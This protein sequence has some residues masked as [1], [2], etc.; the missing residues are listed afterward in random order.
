MTAHMLLSGLSGTVLEYG[1]LL[2]IA[3][4]GTSLSAP[5]AALVTEVRRL[6]A[7]D[8]SATP[9]S[10][11]ASMAAALPG[12]NDELFLLLMRWRPLTEPS[13]VE[14]VRVYAWR[15]GR[16][17]AAE[18]TERRCWLAGRDISWKALGLEMQ[19]HD[20]VR[21]LSAGKVYL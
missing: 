20:I 3:G 6:I 17:E 1:K 8:P 15:A 2:G 13:E 18:L 14:C 4:C 11:A 19:E 7:T 5:N 21:P 9:F 16:L 12:A 10:T